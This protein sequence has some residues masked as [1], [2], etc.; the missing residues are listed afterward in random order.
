MPFL[1]NIITLD[2]TAPPQTEDGASNAFTFSLLG[3]LKD[4]LVT[5]DN[6]LKGFLDIGKAEAGL[7]GGEAGAPGAKE[8]APKKSAASAASPTSASRVRTPVRDRL[9]RV[10]MEKQLE[11][12]RQKYAK[13][14]EDARQ[15]KDKELKKVVDSNK[16]NPKFP[17][18]CCHTTGP[19]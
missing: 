4:S 15:E 6:S 9:A 18:P 10:D 7:E 17:P 1:T 13:D 2:P 16:P 11:E 3:Q 8:A 5:Y 12:Q 19:A 14:L